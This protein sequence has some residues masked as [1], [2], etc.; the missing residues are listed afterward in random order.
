[1]ADYTP[2]LRRRVRAVHHDRSAA[3][4]GGQVL[5]WTGASTVGPTGGVSAKVAGV[6]AFDAASGAR[7]SVWPLETF[8]HELTSS[9]AI[10]AGGGIESG[11]AGAS[12]R[13]PPASRRRRRRHPHRRRRHHGRVQQGPH[14]GPA[15]TT[16]EI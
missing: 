2:G 3:I 16:K 12:L 4:T 8:I 5:E 1:M 7:V 15:L 9:G 6:A 13:R 10:T 11:A 14:P